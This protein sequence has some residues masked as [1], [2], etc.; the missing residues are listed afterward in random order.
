MA[1]R[2]LFTVVSPVADPA[3]AP[4]NT[5][6]ELNDMGVSIDRRSL[7]HPLTL[8]L[9]PGKVYGLIGHNGSGKST[10]MKVLGRQMEAT[11]GQCLFD[12]RPLEQWQTRAF[13][14]RV[15]LLPQ[16]LPSVE[17][18]LGHE[19]LAM[20]RYAWQGLLGRQSHNDQ[21]AI[22]QAITM[23]N[24]QTL[25]HADMASLSGGERQRLWLAMLVAQQTEV[26][27]LDEPTSALDPGHQLEVLALIRRLAEQ[28][29]KCIVIIIHDINMAAR[30]CHHLLAL[31]GGKLVA[32][33][34]PEQLMQPE[35]LQQIYDVPMEVIKRQGQP[36][37]GILR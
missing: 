1:K 18:M 33:G 29:R 23:T 27:L 15:A 16:H 11:T 32:E 28:Q 6:F 25:M 21:D 10:L 24:T 31:K 19:L 12:G 22:E 35:I 7:V 26:M 17:G 37:V 13:A 30:F 9:L 3:K 8:S 4:V 36:P 20:S 34:T 2:H 5:L 14:R